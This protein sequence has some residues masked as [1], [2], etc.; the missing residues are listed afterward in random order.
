MP[1]NWVPPKMPPRF[2][3]NID[4]ISSVNRSFCVKMMVIG[5]KNINFLC[6]KDHLFLFYISL[7]DLQVL[8]YA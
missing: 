7:I 4:L 5:L 3:F 6:R 2:S 1:L 8:N